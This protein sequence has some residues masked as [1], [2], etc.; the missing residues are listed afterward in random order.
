MDKE[1]AFAHVEHEIFY[2]ETKDWDRKK[3]KVKEEYAK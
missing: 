3:K 1:T 2:Y